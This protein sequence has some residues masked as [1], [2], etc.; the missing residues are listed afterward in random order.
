MGHYFL[1]RVVP[2]IRLAGYP[3]FFDIRYPAGYL[4]GRI[5]GYPARKLFQ[6]KTVLTNK[7]ISIY[8]RD[9]H[10]NSVLSHGQ[11]ILYIYRVV[12]I[13]R[14]KKSFSLTHSKMNL[15]A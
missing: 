7:I 11:D 14:D 13:N 15:S 3:A 5:T 1:D 4:A 9:K 10:N 12:T 8:N 6:I 2:D